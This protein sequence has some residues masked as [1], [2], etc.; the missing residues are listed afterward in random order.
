MK[1]CHNLREGDFLT[2][3]VGLPIIMFLVVEY[4]NQIWWL[5]IHN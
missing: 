4:R 1:K 3:T 5:L 2:Q